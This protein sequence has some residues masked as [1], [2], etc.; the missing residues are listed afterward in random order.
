MQPL[1]IKRTDKYAKKVKQAT[2]YNTSFTVLQKTKKMSYPLQD[3]PSNSPMHARR[4]MKF[5]HK[6]EPFTSPSPRDTTSPARLVL[7]GKRLDEG[8]EMGEN[9]NKN[10]RVVLFVCIMRFDEICDGGVEVFCEVWE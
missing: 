10:D 9:V 2:K 1:I 3:H 7:V 8:C 5:I 4:K 6:N